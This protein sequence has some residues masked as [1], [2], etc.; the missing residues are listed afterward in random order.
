MHRSGTSA[1]S[2]LL[3]GLGLDAGSSEGLMASD[4]GNPEGYY[5]QRP[6][7]EL[8]D[9]ILESFGGRWDSPPLLAPGWANERAADHYV[10]RAQGLLASS[11][12]GKHF[13]L[14]D[15][16][17]SLLLPLW[18]KVLLDRGGV[19]LIVRDPSEVAWSLAL[20]D[21]IPPLTGLALWSAYNR[22]ALAELS[23]M[24]VHV[25][26][27]TDLVERPG[28]VVT[29]IVESLR[30]WGEIPLEANLDAAIARVKPALRRN[31]RPTSETELVSL[32]NDVVR[33]MEH[34]SAQVGRHDKYDQGAVPA[35]GWW[36]AP[37]LDERRLTLQRSVVRV[38]ELEAENAD[39]QRDNV[40]LRAQSGE[41]RRELDLVNGALAR[42]RGSWLFRILHAL[43]GRIVDS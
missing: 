24:P 33:L 25:L 34:I 7:V 37:L 6:V 19:V 4:A 27:Y 16:R 5:E 9:E 8:D 38:R 14:K 35:P 30:A 28:E 36:E 15:P 41:L 23:G 20:R 22:A 12:A 2:G 42:L 26:R 40:A 18:R 10:E 13:V 1:V 31:T 29:S 17:V 11:F 3:E 32:P 39:L 21:S 43:A